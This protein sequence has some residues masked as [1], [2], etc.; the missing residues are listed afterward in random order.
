MTG[1]LEDPPTDIDPQ[2]AFQL[3]SHELRLEILFALWEA[4][5]YALPFSGLRDAVGERDSG[6]F[7]YH[8]EKLTGQFVT[9]IEGRYVLQYAGHRVIDAIQSGVFHTSPTVPP[10]EAPGACATC[11]TTP[12]FEYDNHLATVSCSDCETK[13]VEYPFDP[14][15]FQDRSFEEAVEAFDRRTTFKWRLASSGVC[16]V[17]AGRVSVSYTDTAAEIEYNDRYA[18]FF[19]ADHAAL[20]S[21]SCRNCSFYSYIPVGLRLLEAPAVVGQLAMRG[22]DTSDRFLWELPFVTDTD[23]ITVRNRDP[24]TVRVDAPTHGETL[25]V[26]LDEDATVDSLTI[27][28]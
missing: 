17:C 1:P 27:D 3:F 5:E 4:P 15:G 26:T 7:T 14:G 24:W 2:D 22:V 11:G 28:A 16:F 10:R 8:L 23:C 25:A 6:K 9:E 21:L 20:L 18:E 12:T 13:L 19:A